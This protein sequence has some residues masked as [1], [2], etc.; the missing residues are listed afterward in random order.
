MG[1]PTAELWGTG[2]SYEYF[3][4]IGFRLINRAWRIKYQDVK[5]A[6]TPNFIP[7]NRGLDL[8]WLA[9]IMRAGARPAPTIENMG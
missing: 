7:A 3:G 6:A 1:F 9:V 2:A 5:T 8:R 4:E